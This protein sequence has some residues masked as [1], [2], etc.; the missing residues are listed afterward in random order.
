PDHYLERAR[1]EL[2]R[3][4]AAGA[5]AGIDTGIA[6]MG[7][8]PVLEDLAIAI[9]LT[10]GR[11]DAALARLDRMAAVS[12]RKETWLARRGEIV[13]KSGRKDDARSASKAALVATDRLP[14]AM[15]RTKA[16]TDLEDRVRNALASLGA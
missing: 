9:E 2:A 16:M 4:D 1:L 6:K 14:F 15:R 12:Q 7:P 11:I 8:V 13:A 3:N 5:L 10:Q